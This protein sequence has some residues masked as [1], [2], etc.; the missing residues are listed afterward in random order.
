MNHIAMLAVLLAGGGTAIRLAWHRIAARFQ[1]NR[2]D[3]P[4]AH[5]PEA[6]PDPE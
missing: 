1:R 6:T 4:E 2:G 3:A 5:G